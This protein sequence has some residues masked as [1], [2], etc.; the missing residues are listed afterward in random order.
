[1]ATRCSRLQQ[2]GMTELSNC[3]LKQARKSTRRVVE[4]G[5]MRYSRLQNMD[6]MKYLSGCLRRVLMSMLRV[7]GKAARCRRLQKMATI[8]WFNN[9]LN[10]GLMS[11]RMVMGNMTRVERC[12]Q[13]QKRT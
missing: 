8:V 11:T 1:M 6:I 9:Y 7:A 12:R 4:S 5:V 3:C 2:K 13:L 10:G